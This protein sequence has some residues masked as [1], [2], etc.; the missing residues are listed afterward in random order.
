MKLFVTGGAGY[1]GSVVT[2]T[3]LDAGHRVVVFDNLATGHRDAVPEGA[4]FVEGD[5]RDP[6]AIREALSEDVEGVLHFAAASIVAES[7]RDP[8]SYYENNLFGAVHLLRAMRER[9]V[10]R[11]VFS[12]T[13]AVYGE[14]ETVPIEEDAPCRPVN[15]YGETKLA[16]EWL[17]ADASRAWGLRYVALRYFNAAGASERCG[18]DHRP[19]SHLVP[20][21]LDVALGRR[22]ELVVYGDDYP[23][24]D[25]TC[26]RDYIHVLDLADAHLR[27]LEGLDRGVTGPINLGSGRPSSVLDIVK[28]VEKVT[29][30]P[31]PHRIGPRRPGDP[32][33]LVASSARAEQLLGWKPRRGLEDILESAY[34]WR[35]AHPEGYR[36]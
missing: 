11:L 1:I 15:P 27:A 21:A 33:V 16:I 5:L 13:A 26:L 7:V 22:P 30:R 31:L 19:E 28:A 23:T 4:E 2:E 25:G 9:G 36:R 24:P 14:P 29:G 8:L 18:E 32:P 6:E 10:E 34:R 17:L 12:S 20:I 35:L 3:L